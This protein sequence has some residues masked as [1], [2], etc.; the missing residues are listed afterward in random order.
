MLVGWEIPSERAS[1]QNLALWIE[2]MLSI[3][4]KKG[5]FHSACT[6]D[7]D[8]NPFMAVA[9]RLNTAIEFNSAH[10]QIKICRY[11]K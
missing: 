4:N 2:S 8:V 7:F 5:S 6:G 9:R 3:E 11:S 1:E 10:V